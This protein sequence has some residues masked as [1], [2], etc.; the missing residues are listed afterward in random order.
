[1]KLLYRKMHPS[2]GK[3]IDDVLT[4]LQRVIEDPQLTFCWTAGYI[5]LR[6]GG[7]IILAK[8]LA[9]TSEKVR[10]KRHER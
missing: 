8:V 5:A 6:T 1:M 7:H 4:V 3:E 2:F 10:G 9:E